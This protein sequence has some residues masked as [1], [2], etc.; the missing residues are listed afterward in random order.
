ML[1][2]QYRF[3]K[4]P[5]NTTQGAATISRIETDGLL[6][7]YGIER[8]WDNNKPF[9]SCVPDGEYDLIPFVSPKF[10]P[11]FIMV[12]E[13]L[14]VYAHKDDRKADTDRY[15]C[16]FPHVGNYVHEVQGCVALGEGFTV[17]N[18]SA[19]V[20]DSRDAMEFF[21]EIAEFTEGHKLLIASPEGNYGNSE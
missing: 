20:T 3:C 8:P 15:L 21:R 6:L 14:G 7:G 18:T 17:T 2:T 13:S 11:T 10:G 4:Y 16:L 19:M 5:A 1:F 12:N 9:K